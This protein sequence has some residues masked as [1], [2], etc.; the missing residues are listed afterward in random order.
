MH[1]HHACLEAF[2]FTLPEE[3]VTSAQIEERLAPLYRR[4]K[5][6]E[7]RLEMMSGIRER[8]LW[9]AGVL[10]G[11]IS[12]QSAQ[13]AIELSGISRRDIGALV[14]GSVCRDYLEPATASGVH[15]RLGLPAECI[16]Y[17]VSNACLGLLNGI[18][19]VAN[20]IE[21]GQ[22]RAGL[23]VGTEDSRP[24]LETTIAK[25][26]AD[27]SLTRQD[28]KLAFGSLTIGSA[29]V[30]VVLAD[31]EL[32]PT[33]NRL[34]AGA[35]YAHTDHSQLCH[36]GRDEA[37]SEGMRP[38]MN[39]DSETLLVEGVAAAQKSFPRFLQT[40][41]W[42]PDDLD[43]IICH[44]VGRAH[45]KA[46][47]TALGLNLERD[48][49]TLEFLGNT[50]SAALP[51][52]MALAV[53]RGHIRPGDRVGMLGIGSGINVLMLGVQWQKSLVGPTPRVDD[54]RPLAAAR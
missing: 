43:K 22:I 29:S 40:C 14:H 48:F 51:I 46:L 7:G 23:V 45:R 52:S 36:S 38:L 10:P 25:L 17:D 44:Q 33:Q 28:V 20:M 5:L 13:R 26:N 8:R 6:P 31:K 4:L 35:F 3:I 39:T 32:S 19:Q 42:H 24:L 41:G 30:A 1:Y 54:A 47:F 37:A 18:V 12:V 50:G 34:V 11:D 21:L 2:G 27:T 49:S 53:E 16:V 9:P 15:R